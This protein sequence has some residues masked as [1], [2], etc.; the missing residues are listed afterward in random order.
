VKR[1]IVEAPNVAGILPGTSRWN[2]AGAPL[3]KLAAFGI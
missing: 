2:E 3:P 1:E